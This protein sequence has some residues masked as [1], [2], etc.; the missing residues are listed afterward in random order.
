MGLVDEA[1]EAQL[2]PGLKCSTK[3][4]LASLTKTEAADVVEALNDI[5]LTHAGIYR[6]LKNR[7]YEPPTASSIARHRKND[8]NCS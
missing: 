4:L 6:A 2:G 3:I 5:S 1:K 7:G 8:C